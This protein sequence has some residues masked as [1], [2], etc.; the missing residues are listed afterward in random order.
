MI[1]PSALPAD[2]TRIFAGAEMLKNS[3]KYTSRYLYC[4]TTVKHGDQHKDV[5]CAGFPAVSEVYNISFRTVLE[6]RSPIL[7]KI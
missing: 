1:S 3:S 5:S 4:G 7:H 6:Q 2:S